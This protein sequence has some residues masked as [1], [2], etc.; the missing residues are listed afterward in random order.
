MRQS[1]CCGEFGQRDAAGEQR[2]ASR[3]CGFVTRAVAVRMKAAFCSLSCAGE[4]EIAQHDLPRLGIGDGDFQRQRVGRRRGTETRAAPVRRASTSPRIASGRNFASIG[5]RPVGASGCTSSSGADSTLHKAVEQRRL[6][7][8]EREGGQ[9]I[10]PALQ[11][12]LG[13]DGHG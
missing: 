13:D 9:R 8:R 7:R 4:F 2:R 3:R 6:R 10:L 12:A 1:G 5:S 11:L